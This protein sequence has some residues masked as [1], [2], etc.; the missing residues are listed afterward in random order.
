MKLDEIVKV[1]SQPGMG[2]DLSYITNFKVVSHPHLK[3][4]ED[5]TIEQGNSGDN[6]VFVV[7]KEDVIVAVMG[8]QM[9]RMEQNPKQVLQ[10]KRTWCSPLDRN[11]SIITNLYRYV[12]NTLHFSLISDV[13]QS[14]ESISIWTKLSTMWSVQMINTQTAEITPIDPTLLY[15]DRNYALILESDY[16]LFSDTKFRFNYDG[17]VADYVFVMEGFD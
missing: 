13:V 12:Y 9:I 10:V 17:I 1:P 16:M 5:Y 8:T 2:I 6:Y 3:F 4:L 15:G 14:P 7:K 11:K